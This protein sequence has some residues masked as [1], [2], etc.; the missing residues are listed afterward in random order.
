[1]Q[2]GSFRCDANVSVR[3]LG[4]TEF[5][6]RVEIKNLNSFRFLEKAIDYEV[7]RQIECLEDGGRIV[8]ET[9]LYDPDKDQTRSMR[10][11]EDAEDYRYFPDP[12]LL[13]V[14]VSPDW[15]AQV[16]D[17]MPELP[18]AMA[19]RFITDY[20]LS[21]YDAAHLTSSLALAQFFEQTLANS[22]S[23]HAKLIA[24]WLMGE[25]ANQLNRD[26]LTISDSPVTPAQLAQLVTRIADNTINGKIAKEIFMTLWAANNA[27]QTVDAIID[28][29][30]LRQISDTGAIEAVIDAIMAANPTQ[31]ADYRS[32]KDKLFGFFVGQAMKALQGKANPQQLNDLLKAKLSAF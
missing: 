23:T 8:Q 29:Q 14:I 12:D 13:P 19:Q 27:T 9:R 22:S 21:D 4:Q 20:Q 5:G 25:I 28:A 26:T 6:T 18:S 7:R 10:S 3:P 1:M 15:I 11:K 30:G 16:R 24:N 2:E 32:G 31:L 17:T